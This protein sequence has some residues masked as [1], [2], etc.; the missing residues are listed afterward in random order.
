MNFPELNSQEDLDERVGDAL[1]SMMP[2]G[3]LAEP[4]EKLVRIDFTKLSHPKFNMSDLLAKLSET[5]GKHLLDSMRFNWPADLLPTAPLQAPEQANLL[6]FDPK[7]YDFGL[8]ILVEPN[9][10]ERRISEF[11]RSKPLYLSTSGPLVTKTLVIVAQA[12]AS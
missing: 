7:K 5:D 6:D 4:T 2:I 12:K 10:F 11:D 1:R 9:I 8:G 3:P